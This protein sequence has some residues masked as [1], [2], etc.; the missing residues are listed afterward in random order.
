MFFPIR[1]FLFLLCNLTINLYNLTKKESKIICLSQYLWFNLVTK[2]IYANY[3]L[4]ILLFYIGKISNTEIINIIN[5]LKTNKDLQYKYLYND[6]PIN[7]LI[8]EDFTDEHRIY[9]LNVTK[10]KD[11]ENFSHIIMESIKDN[12]EFFL[13]RKGFWR[14][15]NLEI[16]KLDEN[17]KIE[18]YNLLNP[19]VSESTKRT[20][21]TLKSVY[22]H[23]KRKHAEIEEEC[24]NDEHAYSGNNTT[25]CAKNMD[26]YEKLECVRIKNYDIFTI[27]NQTFFLKNIVSSC[28]KENIASAITFLNSTRL[29][30]LNGIYAMHLDSEIHDIV[31]KYAMNENSNKI[32]CFDISDLEKLLSFF[33]ENLDHN[34]N[35]V[36][37]ISKNFQEPNIISKKNAS[38][39]FTDFY[40]HFYTICIHFIFFDNIYKHE[41]EYFSKFETFIDLFIN[42]ILSKKNLFLNENCLNSSEFYCKIT[43]INNF[44]TLIQNDIKIRSH[45]EKKNADDNIKITI[46]LSKLNL[47]DSSDLKCNKDD[48]LNNFMYE[49]DLKHL[50]LISNLKYFNNLHH[51]K[52]K[53][54][55]IDKVFDDY[56]ILLKYYCSFGV[57]KLLSNQDPKNKNLNLY[58]ENVPC[59]DLNAILQCFLPIIKYLRTYTLYFSEIGIF[60]ILNQKINEIHKEIQSEYKKLNDEAE[61]ILLKFNS[62]NI[63]ISKK[64]KIGIEIENLSEKLKLHWIKIC[65]YEYLQILCIAYI[66]KFEFLK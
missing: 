6:V 18:I 40:E 27:N 9:Y 66:L 59:L 38:V 16:I 11:L 2:L 56:Y 37:I 46:D 24:I 49:F 13:F 63:N 22:N 31:E 8:Y 41:L 53:D 12:D 32:V 39:D 21:F 23:N 7:D 35:Y 36:E 29:N 51:I 20:N 43:E 54:T 28:S 45:F 65:Y 26:R 10:A 55:S 44:I 17:I 19:P 60:I 25:N 3:S 1:K 64:E 57:A 30:Y 47:I 15:Q 52:Y 62:E 4:L 34:Q 61:N 48:S 5:S 14:P 58:N 50:N 33:L 42:P